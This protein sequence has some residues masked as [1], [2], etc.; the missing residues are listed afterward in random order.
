MLGSGNAT[1]EI[2]ISIALSRFSVEVLLDGVAFRNRGVAFRAGV[3][4][5]VDLIVGGRN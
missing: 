1:A 3:R 4:V 5:L 2:R